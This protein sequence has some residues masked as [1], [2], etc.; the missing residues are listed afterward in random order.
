MGCHPASVT[1]TVPPAGGG[2]AVRDSK[3]PAGPVLGF[4]ADA[5][6]AFVAGLKG[7]QTRNR[8]DPYNLRG[9]SAVACGAQERRVPRDVSGGCRL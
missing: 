5:F 8:C 1:S 2:V 6:A 9:L 3:D 7:G 4:G